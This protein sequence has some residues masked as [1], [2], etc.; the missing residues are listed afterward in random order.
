MPATSKH[1]KTAEEIGAGILASVQA[2]RDVVSAIADG[3]LPAP[4]LGSTSRKSDTRYAPYFRRGMP[5][6]TTGVPYDLT[7]V[8]QYLEQLV[9]K[10]LTIDTGLGYR[11]AGVWLR[12]AMLLLEGIECGYVD[13][14]FT[15][16]NI[17]EGRVGYRVSSLLSELAARRNAYLE[18][19][20]IVE[21]FESI[22]A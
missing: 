21:L 18:T 7:D 14:Q 5:G 22:P 20:E 10:N 15:F 12:V 2:V 16:N 11:A 17:R 8:A 13:E 1:Y 4:K 9:G 3:R 19:R 6:D